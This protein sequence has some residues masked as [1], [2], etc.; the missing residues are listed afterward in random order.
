MASPH[1]LASFSNLFSP[2]EEQ[3]LISLK[4]H[5]SPALS[6][7]AI[8]ERFNQQFPT[9]PRSKGGLQVHYSRKLQPSKR[10][11]RRP[12]RSSS[13]AGRAESDDEFLPQT[14][15]LTRSRRRVNAPA[16]RPRRSAAKP[17][18]HSYNIIEESDSTLSPT[19]SQTSFHF[20]MGNDQIDNGFDERT[21][22]DSMSPI[23]VKNEKPV[24]STGGAPSRPI[25]V[26]SKAVR[27]SRLMTQDRESSPQMEGEYF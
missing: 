9:S 8:H 5:S 19:D 27:A 6:W 17:R 26:S 4:E 23:R 25:R 12:A 3:H 16:V 22:R 20:A 11:R 2:E 24:T 14:D 10:N 1:H 21:L 7:E 13:M 15:L 18:H